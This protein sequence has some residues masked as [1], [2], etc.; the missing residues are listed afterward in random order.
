[1]TALLATLL[2][3]GVEFNRD[4]RP[5]LADACFTCH[6]P[7]PAQRKAGLRL[8]TADGVKAA[9]ATGEA[10]RRVHDAKKPMPPRAATRQLNAAEKATL[11][12]WIDAGATWQP[13]WAFLAPVKTAPPAARGRALTPIDRFVLARL[14][15]DGRTMSDD[16]PRPTWL[17]RVT[18]DLTGVPATVEEQLAF[19]ADARPDAHERAADRLLAS[20]RF[21]ERFAIRWLEAARYADTSGYQSDGERVMWRWRDWV[22]EAFNGNMPFDRFTVEQLAGDLLPSATLEQRIATGFNRNHRGNAE[23]GIVPEEYAAEYVADRVETSAAVWLGL[24][25]GCARCHDH[26]YDPV[27]QREFYR[28][29][30]FFNNVPERGKAVK[31]GNSPPVLMS[32]T[33]A[34][35]ARLKVLQREFY[36]AFMDRVKLGP[37]ETVLDWQRKPGPADKPQPPL[38]GQIALPGTAPGSEHPDA[39]RFTYTDRFSVS[40]FVTPSAPDGLIVQKA[41][42]EDEGAGW[43]V[44]LRRGRVQVNLVKRW[45]DDSIRVEAEAAVPMRKETHVTVTYD[46]SRWASGLRVYLDGKRAK[47]R[48]LVD[49]LNQPFDVKAPLR[50]GPGPVRDVRLFD[51]DVAPLDAAELASVEA[52]ADLRKTEL[53]KLPAGPAS[54]LYR[55]FLGHHGGEA[56]RQAHRRE[57]EAFRRWQH[58][59]DG[60]PTTMVM[61]EMPTPR[62]TFVLKRGQYDQ[63]G[64]R[65]TP[66]TPAALSPWPD[67]APVNRLGLARWVVEGRNPLTARVAV[68]R[69]W[70]AL[71]GTGLVK[72]SEDFG[73]QGEPPSHPELLDW[74]AVEFRASGW[75]VKRLL[76]LIVTSRVY[77]QSSKVTPSDP[78]NRLLARFPRLRLPAEMIRDQALFAAGLMT[79][80]LGGPSVKPYQPD[81]LWRDLADAEYVRDTGPALYRRGLYVYWKR[82][83][84]PPGALTFDAPGREA[85]SVRET[86]TNTPLQ[87]LNLLNDVTYVEAARVLAERAVREKA[88]D[89][90]R[91][92]WMFRRVLGR[93][94]RDHEARL[95]AES[96]RR[97]RAHYAADPDAAAKLAS[98]GDWPPDAARPVALRAAFTAVAG[99]LLNLDEAINK[100]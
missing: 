93:A 61:E 25:V 26:K 53:D 97:H 85:C 12:G 100:E 37:T 14:E 95:L 74:L 45:L 47:L 72:T 81:G 48:V 57:D 39:G 24:T 27:T 21:G 11:K 29:F 91:I 34:Q 7:D 73:V 76:R 13:H 59:R 16:A 31:F 44:R 35:A 6:G 52:I 56:L 82:T 94:P 78:D 10:W 36:D 66:G 23:G 4:V 32:P 58:F 20:P 50:I 70:Q 28:V 96:Y 1:M 19:E 68:N 99:T 8:D 75:D 65:V 38:P 90:E 87:A 80:E 40:A 77:R 89:A 54:R 64:E 18:L 71:F 98:A 22:I 55:Y 3:A 84:A 17:R 67:G 30:A 62:P 92:A 33:P 2:L 60:L 15:R 51:R 63:P 41:E 69:F 88:D 46:G 49:E 86:R 79:E 42:D 83:V 43:S 9:F 5:I